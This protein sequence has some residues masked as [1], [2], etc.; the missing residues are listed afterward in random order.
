MLIEKNELCPSVVE[1]IEQY[2]QVLNKLQAEFEERTT[3]AL[4]LDK[5]LQ[6]QTAKASS[7]R[8]QLDDVAKSRWV[9]LG[10]LLGVG[11]K[12]AASK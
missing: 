3:W 1:E 5:G 2:N 8:E 9:R 6:E 7:L 4:Q 11:P 10:N 12:L